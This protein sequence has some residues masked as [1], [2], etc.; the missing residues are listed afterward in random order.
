MAT[1]TI[2]RRSVEINIEVEKGSTFRHSLTWR[3]QEQ[4]KDPVDLTG[5]TGRMQIRDNKKSTKVLHEMTTENG[6][7]T[8][9]GADG[10]VE[11]Y[12]SD[13]DSSAWSFYNGSYDLEII[14]PNTDVRRL[15]RGKVTV[16]DEVTR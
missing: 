9:G 3:Y 14:F 16:F 10:T 1:A 8:L 7:I 15:C 6:G 11:M 4:P 2:S 13:S 5:C 12:I